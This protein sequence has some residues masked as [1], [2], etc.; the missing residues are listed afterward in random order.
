MRAV[1]DPS[2]AGMVRTVVEQIAVGAFANG[3]ISAS[4]A[5]AMHPGEPITNPRTTVCDCLNRNHT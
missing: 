5:L 1:G 4:Q 2:V 3:E